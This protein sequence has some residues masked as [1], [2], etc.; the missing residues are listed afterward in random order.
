VN[1][2]TLK[3]LLTDPHLKGG[4]Q[5]RY[6][7]KLARELT[8]LGHDVTIG[9]KRGSILEQGAADAGCA[10]LGQ[11][12]YKGG[13]R[14]R[15]WL[16][17][18]S[19]LRRF[20]DRESPDILH[21]NGSQDH[22]I[23]GLGNRLQGRRTCVVR[24]RHNTDPV[25]EHRLNRWLNDDWTD[26]QIAVCD[27]VREI[28]IAQPVFDPARMETIH[29]GVDVDEFGPDPEARKRVR[30]EFGYSDEHIV[31]GMAARLNIAKGHRFLF[32]AAQSIREKHPNLRLLILGQ[33]ELEAELRADVDRRGLNDIV[34]FAG[35]RTDIGDCIQAFDIGA[36]PSIATEASSFSLMEQMATCIPMI[37]SD[38]GGSK[39]ICRDGEEGFVVRQGESA[40]LA[41]ALERMVSDPALRNAFGRKARE[42]IAAEFTL[43]LLA[44]R[45]VAAY[46][47]ALDVHVRRT[48]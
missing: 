2:R 40:P 17:D 6:V 38:H 42:R 5:V 19:A 8:R 27:A 4:G 36:L 30:Q 31:V 7:T 39:E 43:A 32:E 34:H 35:F 44:E 15:V 16:G 28:R 20:V 1:D 41:T 12:H 47:R 37:V 26:W 10:A 14:P 18:L 22:W 3:I 48:G 25:K 29:N 33:G 21:A 46:R 45:T 24:T 23:S 13:L 9:C 11:F